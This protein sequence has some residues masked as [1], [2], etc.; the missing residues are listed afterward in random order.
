MKPMKVK[1]VGKHQINTY[2]EWARYIYEYK[3][4]SMIEWYNKNFKK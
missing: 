4:N 2:H 1:K 3:L